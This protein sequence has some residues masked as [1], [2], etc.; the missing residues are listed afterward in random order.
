MSCTE[1]L[2]KIANI[3]KKMK[4][5]KKIDDKLLRKLYNEQLL[6]VENMRKFKIKINK[7]IIPYIKDNESDLFHHVPV[8]IKNSIEINTTYILVYTTVISNCTIKLNFY[9]TDNDCINLGKFNKKINNI[10]K[11]VYFLL[12]YSNS[13]PNEINLH[14]YLTDHAKQYDNNVYLNQMNCNTAMT[15]SCQTNIEVVIYRSEEYFKV[16]IHELFHALC[17]DFSSF[18]CEILKKKIAEL[19]PIKQNNLPYEAYAEFWANIIN[20]L[21]FAYSHTKNYKDFK[22]L[23][24]KCLHNEVIF[25]VF[26]MT[27]I[28]NNMGL[29]YQQIMEKPNTYNEYTNVFS[30]YILKTI[31]LYNVNDFMNWCNM[32]N[33]NLFEFRKTDDKIEKLADFIESKYKE[34]K[35]LNFIHEIKNKNIADDDVLSKTLRMTIHDF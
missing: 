19:F 26:Q 33:L 6:V 17:L 10:I 20:C 14:L 27:K 8:K 32:N 29:S 31:L 28:L 34:K 22:Y 23:M 18:P 16:L 13:K 11:L 5:N 4:L 30:Y 12:T 7:T 25:S 2:K 24:N 1:C 21:F 9:I 3:S 35:F 15:Y